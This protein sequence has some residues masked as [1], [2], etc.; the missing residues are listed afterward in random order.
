[1]SKSFKQIFSTKKSW[2]LLAVAVFTAWFI[3]WVFL[4]HTGL[5]VYFPYEPNGKDR[6]IRLTGPLTSEWVSYKELPKMCPAALVA[7]ED[8]QFY[9]HYGIEPNRIKS[10]WERNKKLGRA[11]FGASTITQQFVKNA[12]LS[13]DKSMLR[14]AREIVGAVILDVIMSKEKQIEWYFNVVE[15]GPKTYGIHQAAKLYFK[16]DPKDLTSSECVSLVVVL[17]NPKKWNTSLTRKSLTSF[18]TKRYNVVV[19]RA[20]IMGIAEHKF[21][22]SAKKAGPFGLSTQ[23]S[24][25]TIS[26]RR[27]NEARGMGIILGIPLPAMPPPPENLEEG[28]D[29]FDTESPLETDSAI[30]SGIPVAPPGLEATPILKQ[31]EMAE[32][33]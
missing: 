11:K 3:P 7:S 8:T 28:N 19:Q 21:I 26:I 22:A 33:E 9:Q 25:P 24:D 12:F 18:F 31:T 27:A 4:L 2:V 20:V 30:E 32:P 13:R 1:M 5:L 17:P 15:F 16:K 29:Y 10:V 14:K 23:Y 6:F